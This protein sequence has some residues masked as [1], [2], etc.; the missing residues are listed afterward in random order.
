MEQQHSNG[1]KTL[2]EREGAKKWEKKFA[3]TLPERGRLGRVCAAG[4]PHP[5]GGS[6]A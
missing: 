1:R 3:S 4:S 2:G 6:F 5:P